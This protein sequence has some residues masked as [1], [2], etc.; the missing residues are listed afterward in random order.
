MIDN[1]SGGGKEMVQ[2]SSGRRTKEQN[3]K[4]YRIYPWTPFEIIKT[5]DKILHKSKSSHIYCA[6]V[7]K[8]KYKG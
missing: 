5:L 6:F 3:D 2:S 1:D 8:K 4:F 7:K